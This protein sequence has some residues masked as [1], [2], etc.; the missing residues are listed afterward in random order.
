M[1]SPQKWQLPQPPDLSKPGGSH[2]QHC[3][4]PPQVPTN[5]LPGV[6]QVPPAHECFA[7][8]SLRW[9]TL[10]AVTFL[11]L[12]GPNSISRVTSQPGS[13]GGDTKMVKTGAL[14]PRTPRLNLGD[15]AP[16]PSCLPASG[17]PPPTPSN[18]PNLGQLQS[19]LL[20][21]QA[22]RVTCQPYSG[23][24]Q[25][26][27]RL[28]PSLAVYNP[29]SFQSPPCSKSSNYLPARVQVGTTA[30]RRLLPPPVPTALGC[31]PPEPHL[32]DQRP[33]PRRPVEV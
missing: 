30:R 16:E 10:N 2:L 25:L 9:G 27:T 18:S 5:L 1:G 24:G 14:R 6:L 21:P 22:S 15:V 28:P 33:P 3:C 13:P 26:R 12:P 11:P 8:L 20:Y 31:R 32:S 23:L 4:A 7:D 17:S 19:S 29:G